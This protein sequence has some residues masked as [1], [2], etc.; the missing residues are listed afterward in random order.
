M[1][2]SNSGRFKQIEQVWLFS[3]DPRHH[4]PAGRKCRPLSAPP[5]VS[6]MGLAH[7]LPT[8]SPLRWPYLPSMWVSLETADMIREGSQLGRMI[9]EWAARVRRWIGFQ[10]LFSR[11]RRHLMLLRHLGATP[12]A[13][14]HLATCR[15]GK[16]THRVFTMTQRLVRHLRHIRIKA[17]NP[18]KNALR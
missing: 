15:Q 9:T 6:Q 2:G 16:Q 14:V 4:W 13:P 1:A 18:H 12:Q 17:F 7:L 10:C 3:P 5:S 8:F 11:R